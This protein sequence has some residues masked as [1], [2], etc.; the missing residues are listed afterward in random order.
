MISILLPNFRWRVNRSEQRRPIYCFATRRSND[1]L[2]YDR[3]ADDLK[4]HAGRLPIDEA[5]SAWALE[6]A[7]SGGHMSEFNPDGVAQVTVKVT[8]MVRGLLLAPLD[9]IVT[10]PL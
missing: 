2:R 4:A 7:S 5:A 1:L 3:D 8:V 9:V 10:D 6:P